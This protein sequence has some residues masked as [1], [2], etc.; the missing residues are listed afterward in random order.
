[1]KYRIDHYLPRQ[2]EIERRS[3]LWVP[4]EWLEVRCRRLSAGVSGSPHL[5]SGVPLVPGAWQLAGRE[6]LQGLGGRRQARDARRPLRVEVGEDAERRRP[7]R[8]VGTD[9]RCAVEADAA[10]READ[11]RVGA[12]MSFVSREGVTERG[13]WAVGSGCPCPDA[14]LP[15]ARRT[16]RACGSTTARRRLGARTASPAA[17]HRRARARQ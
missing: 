14:P 5:I 12:G 10:V 6:V 17:S 2:L 3:Y 13:R 1:M 8:S 11:R 4:P 16:R 15:L 9:G 7:H